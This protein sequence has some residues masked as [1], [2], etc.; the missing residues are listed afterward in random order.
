MHVRHRWVAYLASVKRL[1]SRESVLS[2]YA[3]N[4]RSGIAQDCVEWSLSLIDAVSEPPHGHRKESRQ[5]NQP[6]Q[7]SYDDE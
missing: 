2:I 1:K 3:G 4:W 7:N 6:A 5:A